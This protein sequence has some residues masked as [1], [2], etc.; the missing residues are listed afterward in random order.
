ML[1]ST[2]KSHTESS[3][4][5]SAEI[6]VPQNSF[7]A[8][9]ESVGNNRHFLRGANARGRE[10]A[11]FATDTVL[12]NRSPM[13]EFSSSS[14]VPST[15]PSTPPLS[16]RPFIL[17]FIYPLSYSFVPP[18]VCPYIVLYC[19]YIFHTLSLFRIQGSNRGKTIKNR[20]LSNTLWSLANFF[21]RHCR[22]VDKNQFLNYTHP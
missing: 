19:L 8:L 10:R 4:S 9:M 11:H 16:M 15:F 20:I 3:A 18:P 6:I 2:E 14:I 17:F 13:Q 7:T 5:F 12:P 1:A 21:H 22:G